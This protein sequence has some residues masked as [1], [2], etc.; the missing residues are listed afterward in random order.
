LVSTNGDFPMATVFVR[1][2]DGTDLAFSPSPAR[3]G[4]VEVRDLHAAL[5]AHSAAVAGFED[6]TEMVPVKFSDPDGY[7]VEVYWES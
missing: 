6:D 4:A 7:V 1:D 2:T 3:G 5:V